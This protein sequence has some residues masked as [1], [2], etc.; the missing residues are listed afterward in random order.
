MYWTNS[1]YFEE[2]IKATHI[3]LCLFAFSDTF[4]TLVCKN[5]VIS[6]GAIIN[7]ESSLNE[8]LQYLTTAQILYKLLIGQI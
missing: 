7:R 2:Y 8:C 6:K 3:T 4:F 5:F 1:A